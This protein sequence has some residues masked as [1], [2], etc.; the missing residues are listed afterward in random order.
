MN[1]RLQDRRIADLEEELARLRAHGV[2]APRNF[3]DKSVTS[4]ELHTLRM[5]MERSEM[6]LAQKY[7]LHLF[8]WRCFRIRE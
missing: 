4:H 7:V 6:E 3:T 5:K 2:D 8:R 1:A